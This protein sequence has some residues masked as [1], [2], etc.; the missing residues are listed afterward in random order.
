MVATQNYGRH[1]KR[2]HPQEDSKD[3]RPFGFQKFSFGGPKEG[4]VKKQEE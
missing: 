4:E 3:R 2:F 1:L